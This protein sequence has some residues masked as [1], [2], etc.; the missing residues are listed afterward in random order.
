MF[1]TFILPSVR[2]LEIW[3]CPNMG[4]FHIYFVSGVLLLL[5]IAEQLRTVTVPLLDVEEEMEISVLFKILPGFIIF[6]LYIRR[7]LAY[8]HVPVFNVPTTLAEDGLLLD[9]EHP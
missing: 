4:P 2:I 3:S 7:H 1:D 8:M 6:H 5:D 9:T